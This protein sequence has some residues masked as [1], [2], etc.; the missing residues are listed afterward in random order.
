[1]FIRSL[2]LPAAHEVGIISS[3]ISKETEVQRDE[4]HASSYLTRK[5]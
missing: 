5:L 3:F 4:Y 1:M 2:I